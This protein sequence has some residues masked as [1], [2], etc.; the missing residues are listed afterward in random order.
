MTRIIEDVKLDF[1]DVL[2]MPKR[3]GLASRAEVQLI[4]TLK[5]KHSKHV[6]EGVGIIVA[7]M[8]HTGTMKMHDAVMQSGL[9]T[10][11]HKF[12]SVGHLTDFFCYEK[13]QQPFYTMGVTD[14]DYLKFKKVWSDLSE[15][16]RPK[17]VCI[18]VANGYS[19]NL[20]RMVGRMREAY[21]H[22]VIMAGNVVTGDMVYD[23]LEKG[24]DIVKV[25]IGGGSVC[26]TR[27]VTGV[28]YPQLSAIMECADAAHGREKGLICA[29]GGITCPGDVAKAFAAGADFVMCG[30][31]FAGHDECDG[32]I[33]ESFIDMGVTK[34]RFMKFH[35]MSSKE[36]MDQHYGGT[37]SYRAAEGKEVQVPY[38]GPVIETVQEILGGLRS[39]CTYV[40]ATQLKHLPKC[41]TFVKVNRILNNSLSQ[42]DI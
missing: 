32:E 40:G 38:K 5:F 28:G 21:S 15:D 24:A 6:Y 25:G 1:Q 37:S 42:Y 39:S 10:A 13:L 31:L 41:A 7:N 34:Q 20:A 18:D 26:T 17:Y 23:L 19:H 29:D 8:D 27:R 3:S 2:L 30:S 22:L 4:R 9:T 36:A 12:Y 35:G 33:V 16:W 14:E 11:L